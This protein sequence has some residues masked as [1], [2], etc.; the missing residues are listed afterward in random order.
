MKNEEISRTALTDIKFKGGSI[1][2]NGEDVNV[3]YKLRA[4]DA[5][6]VIFPAENP[7]DGLQGEDIPLTVLF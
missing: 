4:G 7:S 1:Q 6:T 3:R 5:L 2:V